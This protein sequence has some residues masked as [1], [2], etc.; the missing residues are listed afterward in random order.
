MQGSEAA[1]PLGALAVLLVFLAALL[2]F[3]FG[4]SQREIWRNDEHRYV[5][6]GRVMTLPGSSVLVPHLNGVPYTH[7]PPL[8]FWGVATF[9]QLGLEPGD[10]G[11][12]VSAL[13][14]ALTV[15]LCFALG[16]RL[17]GPR[18]GLAAAVVLASAEMF[19]SLELRANLDALLTACITASL[20][21]YWRSEQTR[22]DDPSRRTGWLLA[23]G[24]VAGLGVLVKGP[25]AVA[26]PLSVIVGHDLLQRRGLSAWDRGRAL[27]LV[28]CLAP[29]LAWLAAATAEGGIDYARDLVI[30]HGVAHP[31]GGV[32]KLRPFWYYLSAFPAGLLPWTIALPAALVSLGRPRRSED[33]FALAWL[34]APLLLLS[35]FP[36]KRHLYA[37]PVH[38][39]AALIVGCWLARSATPAAGPRADRVLRGLRRF[40]RAT[41]GLAGLVL[42]LAALG[43]TLLLLA[44]RADLLEPLRLPLAL[45]TSLGPS[46]RLSALAAGGLLVWAGR[47]LAF[48]NEERSLLPAA[49]ALGAGTSLFFVSVLH[50]MESTAQNVTR[51]YAGVAQRVGDEPLAVYGRKDLSPNWTLRRAEVPRLVSPEEAD[52]FRRGA[53]PRTA[54]LVAQER[55]FRKYAW[56]VG[57]QPVPDAEQRPGRAL[58]LLRSDQAGSPPPRD[59]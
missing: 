52:A 45:T 35:L 55:A 7:K 37:L 6:V 29:V 9:S 4:A 36:A 51:F 27:A 25:V 26:I 16:R 42:G 2:L 44:G 20:Y 1:R 40:A 53:S 11:M 47:R 59:R 5:E 3:A 39:G 18:E 21:G 50:P 46:A 15:A 38:P 57:F 24:F 48:G 30:G 14:G 13:A 19:L 23:A 49:L 56:P 43:G 12:A 41:L 28:A 22:N 31:L 17:W 32:N 34:V 8:F 58:V 33:A 54:W 10:A